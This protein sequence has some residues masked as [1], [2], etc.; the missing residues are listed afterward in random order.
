MKIIQRGDVL[1]VSDVRELLARTS[2]VFQAQLQALMPSAV[3]E[4]HID[5]ANTDLVDCRGV[6]VLIG[7]KKDAAG[8]R[9]RRV[10][11][12]NPNRSVQRLLK[13]A[14]LDQTF[15]AASAGSEPA[16]PVAPN[17]EIG[18]SHLAGSQAATPAPKLP[19]TPN[20]ADAP[21]AVTAPTELQ[22]ALA[23]LQM[24]AQA[25]SSSAPGV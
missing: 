17:L 18:A 19:I 23:I 4:I 13:L 24:A 8:G 16:S 25:A 22:A 12:T 9:S 11:F 10:R 14:G 15:T 20:P 21:G 2:D 3:S 7:L 6:G 1:N 5:F